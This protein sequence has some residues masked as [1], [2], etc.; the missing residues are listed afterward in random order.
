MFLCVFEFF[1]GVYQILCVLPCDSAAPKVAALVQHVL[2]EIQPVCGWPA[3]KMHQK[4]QH[5]LLFQTSWIQKSLKMVSF[6][7][8]SLLSCTS[9]ALVALDVLESLLECVTG[10]R[11]LFPKCTGERP[12][13]EETAQ[14][15]SPVA[16]IIQNKSLEGKIF[17]TSPADLF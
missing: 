9:R 10:V 16:D 13:I 14:A 15:M 6:I 8:L 17:K 12:S 11:Y 4:S 1:C 7:V 3:L 2:V 5:D